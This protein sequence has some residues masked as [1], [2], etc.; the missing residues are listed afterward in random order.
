MSPAISKK[1]HNLKIENCVLFRGLA[2]DP[3]PENSFSDSSEGLLQAW[4]FSNPPNKM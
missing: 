1:I 2:E 4:V 3:I